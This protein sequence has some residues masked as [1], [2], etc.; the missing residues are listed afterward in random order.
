M[1]ALLFVILIDLLCGC[2]LGPD[3]RQPPPPTVGSY[4]PEALPPQTIAVD[5]A[6]GESQ[7]FVGG[8][9]VPEQWW[10]LFQSPDLDHLVQEAFTSNPTVQGAQAALRQANEDYLAQRGTLLPTAQANYSFERQ[11][12]ATG[13]LAPTLSSGESIFN[14]HSA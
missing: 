11:R 12:N 8:M 4:L 13:T 10:K 7:R 14:L 2:A 5:V 3:F 6:G 9:N 1:R